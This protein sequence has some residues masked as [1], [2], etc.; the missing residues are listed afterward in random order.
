[1]L[2]L[3][4]GEDMGASWRAAAGMLAPQIEAAPED[5]LFELAV[6]GRELYPRLADDLR[7]STGIDVQFW[8][9]GIVRLATAIGDDK[10]LQ[11]RV[12]WQRRRGH[13]VSFAKSAVNAR[14]G[15]AGIDV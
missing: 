12:A 4:R 2:L 5:P 9:K 8:R 3:E 10:S 14:G 7:A 13:D 6:A 11:A 15:A 1:V